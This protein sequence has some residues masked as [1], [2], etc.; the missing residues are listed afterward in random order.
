MTATGLPQDIQSKYDHLKSLLSSMG[1]VLIAYSGGVDSTL[2]YKVAMDVLGK[3]CLGVTVASELLTESELNDA[4][5]TAKQ[6]GGPHQLLPA[7]VLTNEKV[8][9]NPPERCYHCKQ[10]VYASLL[11]IAEEKGF[12]YVLDGFNADD[13]GD[14]RPGS[15][16]GKEMGIRSPLFEAGLGKNE[17]RAISKMLGL[18]TW[19]KP[20][21]ACLAS[22]IPYGQ[23][24]T[25]EK[26]AQIEQAE[27]YLRELGLNNLRVRHYQDTAR[28]EVMPENFA[29]I[30]GELAS[31]IVSRFKQLGFVYVTL[32]LQGLRSGSMNEVLPK[33]GLNV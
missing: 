12:Q 2:L 13:P 5:Q 3:Q 8:V 32:D 20:S 16:A 10:V 30:A 9:E 7:S 31:K 1:S 26:L 21:A 23:H 11:A 29:R 4:L 22:R 6:L 33:N 19:D 24:L 27:A 18:P 15:Q 17:I 28:I 14:F 25:G